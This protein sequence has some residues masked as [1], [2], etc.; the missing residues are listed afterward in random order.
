VS[1]SYGDSRAL[2]SRCPYARGGEPLLSWA[3]Y[4]CRMANPL[5]W[6]RIKETYDGTPEVPNNRADQGFTYRAEVPGGWLVGVWAGKDASHAWGGGLTFVP[7][8]D[9]KAWEVATF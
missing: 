9:H 7:D 1:R 2:R 8:P 3:C 5:Q 4:S 6:K